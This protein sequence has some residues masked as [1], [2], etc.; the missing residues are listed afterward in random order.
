[1]SQFHFDPDSY[2]AMMRKDMPRYDELQDVVAAST[3][4]LDARRILELGTGT[5]ETARR[6]LAAHP[7]ASLVGI[8]AS[9]AMLAVARAYLNADLRVQ[10]LEDRLPEGPFDLVVSALVVHHLEADEKRDLFRR[11]REELTPGGR[12]V[13]ADLIVPERADDIVTPATPAFDKPDTLADQLAWLGEAG[14]R[15]SVEWSWKDLAAIRAD[16]PS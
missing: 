13:L 7:D 8:D 12:F 10:R 2:L 15:T 6:L 14:F 4:E 1:M 16:V 5:G 11:V 3:A 9:E